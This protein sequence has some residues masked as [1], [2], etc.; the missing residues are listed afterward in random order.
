[1]DELA[2]I[3]TGR[4]V[5]PEVFL[6]G[7]D[8]LLPT[9]RARSAEVERLGRIPDD[10]MRD[11]TGAHVFRVVQPRQWGG[12]EL[13]PATFF[14]G[15]VR[16]ASACGSTG[17]VASVVGIHPWQVALF[18]EA[19]QRDVWANNPD[20]RISSS[21]APTGKVQRASGGFHLSGR[22]G[23]SSGVDHCEWA[24]LGGHVPPVGEGT[25]EYR[26]FLVPVRDCA[27]DHASWNVTGLAGTGSK[28]LVIAGA[29]IPEHRTHSILDV[30]QRSDPGFAVNDRPLFR[31]PWH[32]M[33]CYAIASPS[34]G[35][36][37]GALDAF[38]ENN[39]M[40]ISSFGGPQVALN[41]GLQRRL[42]SALTEVDAARTRVTKTWRALLSLVEAGQ[43]IPY[44][45]RAQCKYEGA[46][47]LATCARA[48]FEVL[49]MNG[50]RTM[51]ADMPFQRYFR[52]LLAMR[53]H[54]AAG[55]EAAAT[56]YAGAKLRVEPPPFTPSQ[57]SVL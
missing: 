4:T 43:E 53:N 33:F 15:M 40:R 26:T 54:P 5:A 41:P 36:A 34:I 18:A 24:L 8:A 31:L 10:I 20:S 57:R 48:V 30:Y 7:I 11:L 39:Q 44:E 1:M 56:L 51:H 37:T 22:W 38:I 19:A 25:P 49:E 52:D 13:D 55:L 45:R 9:I 27:I 50:G 47:A 46:H 17:W 29:F 2:H 28:D 14:E 6:S 3:V 35:A 12:L 23:F 21:L 42:A 32:L 16:I